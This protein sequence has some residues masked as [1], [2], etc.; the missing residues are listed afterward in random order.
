MTRLSALFVNYNSWRL[1]VDGLLSLRN[2]PP[3][4]AD[5]APMDYEVIVVDNCSPQADPEAEADLQDLLG[6]MHGRLIR[7][8]ENSGYAQGMN[9][10]LTHATG[11]WILVSNPDVLFQPD[12]LS[13]L[14]RHLESHPGTGAAAP[15]SPSVKT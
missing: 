7:N 6:Q 8:Q 2:N 10:A 1:C 15:A 11:D 13:L 3:L 5:G 9:L 14:L 12:C 4:S